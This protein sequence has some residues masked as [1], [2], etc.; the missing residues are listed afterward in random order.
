MAETRHHIRRLAAIEAR[1]QQYMTMRRAGRT[2][3]EA[4][5]LLGMS[6]TIRQKIE[7]HYQAEYA[8]GQQGE[9]LDDRQYVAAVE[10]EGGFGRYLETRGQNGEPR[11]TGPYVPWSIERRVTGAMS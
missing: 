7:S 8:P 9:F 2:S 5:D 3:V 4:A 10:A 11:L 6:K 1:D